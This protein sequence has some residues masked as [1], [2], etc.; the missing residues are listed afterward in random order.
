MTSKN[1][2]HG[3]EAQ[4]IVMANPQTAILD[5]LIPGFSL[6]STALEQYL[7]IDV[8][9]YIP[10]A[11]ATGLFVFIFRYVNEWLWNLVELYGTCCADCRP[12]DET[13]NSKCTND[14]FCKSTIC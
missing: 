1:I 14:S 9:L 2:T 7:F 11:L 13:Y 3:H 10:I 12:D 6:I 4:H 5:M 8:S